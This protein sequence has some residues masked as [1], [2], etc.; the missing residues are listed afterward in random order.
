M[1]AKRKLLVIDVAALG[2][3]LVSH[4]N[5]FRPA[6]AIFPAVTCPVQASFRTGQPTGGHGL[7]AIGLFF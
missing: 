4:L 2:W 7:V 5:E 3:N 6:E 1:S